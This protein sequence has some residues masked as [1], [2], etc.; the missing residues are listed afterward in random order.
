MIRR[1]NSISDESFQTR[2]KVIGCMKQ[3]LLGGRWPRPTKNI[4]PVDKKCSIY[5]II[6]VTSFTR[7]HGGQTYLFDSGQLRSGGGVSTPGPNRIEKNPSGGFL[8]PLE[9]R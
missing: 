6:T 3:F 2:I 4:S 9:G 5:T 8:T 1:L 7:S